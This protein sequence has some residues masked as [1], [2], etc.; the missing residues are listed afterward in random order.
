MRYPTE[1]EVRVALLERM[2][3][4][5]IVTGTPL[6]EISR[7]AIG[8]HGFIY[9]IARGGDFRISSF[10]RVMRWLDG[11]T[12]RDRIPPFEDDDKDRVLRDEVATAIEQLKS[13]GLRP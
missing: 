8:R 2:L 1:D 3:E 5:S 6:W 9:E 10:G 4:H 13:E 7:S 12:D 11:H